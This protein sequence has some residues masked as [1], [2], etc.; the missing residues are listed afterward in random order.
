[1]LTQS[2]EW[3]QLHIPTLST[4]SHTIL[5][6]YIS[7]LGLVES[8]PPPEDHIEVVYFDTS[9]PEE[10]SLK[11][12]FLTRLIIL[13]NACLTQ[14]IVFKESSALPPAVSTLPPATGGNRAI[15][16]GKGLGLCK[17]CDKSFLF[18]GFS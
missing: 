12:N 9:A 13:N 15:V 3:K 8:P 5:F 17:S 6:S 4:A 7:N 14:P 1:M 16:A 2:N 10:V 18:S 11:C